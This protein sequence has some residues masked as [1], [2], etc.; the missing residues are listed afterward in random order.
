[1]GK[2]KARRLISPVSAALRELRQRTGHSQETLARDL[3]VSVQT[4]VLWETKRPP[5][6]IMLARLAEMARL[7]G[8]ADLKDTFEQAIQKLPA[9]QAA[10]IQ[11]ERKRWDLVFCR[12]DEIEVQAQREDMQVVE[13]RCKE[14]RGLLN[15]ILAFNWRN[16]K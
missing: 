9:V 4:C 16:Q 10:D 1:M 11:K 15:E 5:S 13:F 7:Y 8:H 3:M 12:L 2:T 14:I 6:G